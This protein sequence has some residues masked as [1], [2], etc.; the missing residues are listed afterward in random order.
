[1]KIRLTVIIIL[2]FCLPNKGNTQFLKQSET[3]NKKRIIPS[4]TGIGTIW[5]GGM[6]G[7][8]QLWYK[9]TNSTNFHSF[10][11]CSNWLQ[12]DKAGH[13]Y[14]TYQIGNYWTNLLKWGGMNN[15]IATITGTAIGFGFQT[16]LEIFDGFSDGWGFSWCDMG[17]NFLGGAIFSSQELIWNEQKIKL[18]FSY[19]PTEFAKYRPSVL[20][21]TF[22]ERLLKD[23][24]GQT[25][26]ISFNPFVLSGNGTKF[27]K[28]ICLSL[29]YSVHEKLYGD[30][31]Y[32]STEINNTTI[33]FKSKREF[34]L[35]LDIDLSKVPV[36]KDWI[37]SL[38]NQFNCLKI[39]FP[40]LILRGNQLTGSLLY[41]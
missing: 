23:Y 32:F 34:L 18:K 2:L 40:A 14:T 33:S 24:N 31:E 38:L 17:A 41:F 29:G 3:F 21:N 20:G 7:L 13:L 15:R 12:M 25:Y 4:I 9:E 22:S 37:R 8:Y 10:N 19:H 28:W 36:K 1:M 11:D 35:S 16:S 39:P 5:G 6:I 27:P 30:N 26:W